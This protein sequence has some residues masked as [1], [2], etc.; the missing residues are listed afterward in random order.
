MSL[1]D[2]SNSLKITD[3]EADTIID[4]FVTIKKLTI[5]LPAY[6]RF[7]LWLVNLAS[8]FFTAS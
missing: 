6:A 4:L 1:M 2:M 7:A 8:R 3:N 5:L